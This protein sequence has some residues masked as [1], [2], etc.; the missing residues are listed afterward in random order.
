[1]PDRF[2]GKVIVITGAA[3]GMGATH[4]QGFIAEGG[5]VVLADV[6]DEAGKQLA[7]ELGDGARCHHL[8]VSSEADWQKLVEFAETE[9][10]PISVM[11]NN[12][13]IALRGVRK[14][15]EKEH[16]ERTRHVAVSSHRRRR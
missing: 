2:E 13:G 6:K 5:S 9:F 16:H 12:A 14:Q 3:S 10:G 7:D 4:A 8:D 1:M 11:V 15:K